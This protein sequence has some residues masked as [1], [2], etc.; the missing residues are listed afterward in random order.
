MQLPYYSAH[1]FGYEG[2]RQAEMAMK[3]KREILS[4]LNNANFTE[5]IITKEY[6]NFVRYCDGSGGDKF[7]LEIYGF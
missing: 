5:S 1:Q 6:L 3:S 4:I 7:P 2:K